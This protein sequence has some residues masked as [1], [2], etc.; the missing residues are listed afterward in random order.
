MRSC[1]VQRLLT[2]GGVQTAT[3]HNLHTPIAAARIRMLFP[4]AKAIAT[5]KEPLWR[6]RSAYSQ[7]SA[8]FM[9]QCSPGQP[10]DWCP[11]FKYYQLR[12]PTFAQAVQQEIAYMKGSG[13]DHTYLFTCR[14]FYCH[15]QIA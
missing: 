8:E 4:D 6:M 2:V 9:A 3:P 14:A 12:L 5:I 10:A 13:A 7:F 1:P 15:W 11:A